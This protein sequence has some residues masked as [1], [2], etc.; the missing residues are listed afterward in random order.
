MT[1]PHIRRFAASFAVG[2]ALLFGCLAQPDVQGEEFK[3]SQKVLIQYDKFGVPHITA[4]NDAD[5]YFAQ[6]FVTARDRLWQMDC[7]RRVA[8]GRLSEILGESK[9]QQDFETR[10]IGLYR[11]AAATYGSFNEEMKK[12]LTA[13]AAGVNHYIN[14]HKDDLPREFKDLGYVPEPW[15]PVDSAANLILM[16][17]RLSGFFEEE[18]MLGKLVDEMGAEN[19]LELVSGEPADPI[20]PIKWKGTAASIPKDLGRG[21]F[22]ILSGIEDLSG[23]S[24]AAY[25]VGSNNW[26]IDGT[27]SETGAPILANDPHLA[28]SNP[29]VWHEIHLAGPGVNVTGSTFPGVPNVIVG[30]NEHIAWGVTNARYDVC[31]LYIE[32]LDAQNKDNYIYKGESKPFEKVT[33]KIRY[34]VGDSMKEV[35][36]EIRFTIHG[37]VIAEE[38][39]KAISMRWIGHEPSTEFKFLYL[40]NRASN[41]EEFKNALRYYGFAA[42]N[43]IYA[44][45]DGNI[46]Y[47]PTGKVPL[48][49][50]APY[51]PL[52]GSSGEYEWKGYI[53]FEEL[54]SLLNP[55]EHFIATAN[56]RPVDSAYPYY[57]GRHFDIGYRA[58]RISDLLAAKEKLTFEDVRAIQADVYVLAAERLKP[59]LLAAIEQEKS[60]L[61]ERTINAAKAVEEW[62]NQATIESSACSIF[63]KWMERIAFNTL[64]DDLGDQSFRYWASNPDTIIL[65]LLRSAREGM[66][67]RDW[68]D[69][70]GTETKET[71]QQIIARSLQE[72]VD[73]LGLTF[74][75]D[76]GEWQWKKLHTITLRHALSKR[77]RAYDNGPYPR[78]GSCH[79]VDHAAF[80][81]FEG[82]FASVGGPS[83]R[84]TVELK[85]GVGHAVN[86]LPGGESGDPSSAHYEDQLENLWLAHGAHPMVFTKEQIQENL[87]KTMALEPTE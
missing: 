23:D 54:P 3:L 73:E 29:P 41:L 34:K 61:P 68:F 69:I 1:G 40:V 15:R 65:L 28:L 67:K 38:D 37:P 78:N 18:L 39:N 77:N 21:D 35:D 57:I 79:T 2:L 76:I 84:M 63:N 82:S 42:Q 24:E 55:A 70:S 9:I 43:F 25:F 17:W 59:Q 62:D 5:L 64:K 8:E 6:G 51:L 31:D 45:T 7:S 87:E 16:F 74:G 56:T 12:L 47:Q 11:A 80:P 32:K 13:F 58:R 26:V 22:E 75:Y 19:A 81:F 10:R 66:L 52:D 36:R 53:P 60:L 46:F 72:A 83:L 30:H 50:G 71:K 33:E 49:K 86:V 27:K 20:T 44:D 85:P 48:R 4:S 14:T